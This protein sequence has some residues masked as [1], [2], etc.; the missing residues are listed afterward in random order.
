MHFEKLSGHQREVSVQ[1]GTRLK[2]SRENVI[3]KMDVLVNPCILENVNAVLT[4]IPVN[5]NPEMYSE[6]IAQYLT[7]K[8]QV[9]YD[10]TAY[11][12]V[13]DWV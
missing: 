1:N 5:E 9:Q 6:E 11:H 12:R 10:S 2:T 8:R 4:Q 13:H 7:S 3:A